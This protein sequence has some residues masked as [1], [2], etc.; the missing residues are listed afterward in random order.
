MVGALGD[1]VRQAALAGLEAEAGQELLVD[2]EGHLVSAR[3][4]VVALPL[5]A[6]GA[7]LEV[8][9]LLCQSYATGVCLSSGHLPKRAQVPLFAWFWTISST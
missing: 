5:I 1:H 8:L 3:Q 7:G 4:L 9:D 2:G 6:I